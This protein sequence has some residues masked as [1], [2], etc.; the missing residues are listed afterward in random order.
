MKADGTSERSEG[1]NQEGNKMIA[2][3][4]NKPLFDLGQT[5]ATPAAL[6]AIATAEQNHSQF[7]QRHVTGD[8]G[9][10]CDEDRELNVAA[11][12]D[13]SRLLSVYHTKFDVK[14]Y[15]ITEAKDDEGQRAATTILLP[16]E[17]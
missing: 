6:E 15:C 8:F 1:V 16:E 17:Y 14:L 2:M 13:G 3:N 11:I 9:D 4:T 10:L 12:E 5:V 7:I